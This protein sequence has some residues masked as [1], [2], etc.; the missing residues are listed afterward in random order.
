MA[1]HRFRVA[2]TIPT[3]PWNRG[4]RTLGDGVIGSTRGFGPRSPGSSPGPPATRNEWF[5][6]VAVKAIVLAAGKGTR[7]NSDM[8]KVLHPVA[9]RPM[10]DYALE[11]LAEVGCEQTVVVVGHQANEVRAMLPLGV[12]SALQEE[13]L[14]TGHAARVGF[15]A[16]GVEDADEIIVMPGDMPLIGSDS[17]SDLLQVHRSTSAAATLLSV[18]LDEPRAYGRIIRTEQ[19]V[20][21]IVEA[22]D[23][24]PEQ[25]EIREVGTS[26]YVFSARWFG[27]ALGRITTDN[28]QRE[29]YLTDVIGLL[30]G[31]GH[32][33]SA[34]ITS[35][36][37][38]LGINS[39]EQI[40][41]V[42]AV[43][44]ER[45]RG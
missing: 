3:R 17:L 37:E 4:P 9:G 33:V 24:T 8:A 22:R 11:A 39:I 26:V 23:A 20:A 10:L 2:P 32:A 42:E 38:G 45:L 43:L 30:V 21:G 31:D 1:D 6:E 19:G 14:G 27:G 13:Q 29:Y 25:L 44:R 12:D 15:N 35:P 5:H 36:E 18:E 7:M 28:A 41:E 16:L 34:H 40:A